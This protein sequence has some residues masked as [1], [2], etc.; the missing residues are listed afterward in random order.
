MKKHLPK[1]MEFFTP[2]LAHKGQN[3]FYTMSESL[4]NEAVQKIKKIQRAAVES[5]YKI[6]QDPTSQGDLPYFTIN[7][8][9]IM[10]YSLEEVQK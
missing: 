5:I 9:E 7:M 1:L 2:E 3:I 8:G 4:N 10:D 6:I